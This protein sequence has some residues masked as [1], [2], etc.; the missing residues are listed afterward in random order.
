MK[1]KKISQLDMIEYMT[2]QQKFGNAMCNYIYS[3][4]KLKYGKVA[5]TELNIKTSI[6]CR[7]LRIYLRFDNSVINQKEIIKDLCL[8]F[9]LKPVK[10][11]EY[12]LCYYSLLI[13]NIEFTNSLIRMNIL[14]ENIL[15]NFEKT[16][17]IRV[18][19]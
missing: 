5:Y 15:E 17:N 1:I 19:N 18:I 9:G 6:K 3:V 12:K 11:L 2:L 14:G 16:L 8:Y 4:Y 10:D 7:K 13:D